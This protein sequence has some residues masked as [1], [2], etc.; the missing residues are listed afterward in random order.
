[1]IILWQQ[2]KLKLDAQVGVITSNSKFLRIFDTV[3]HLELSKVPGKAM[4][5]MKVTYKLDDSGDK[6]NIQI[7]AHK[8]PTEGKTGETVESGNKNI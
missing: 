2:Q 3:E 5:V 4:K 7:G 1:M 8:D 6:Y